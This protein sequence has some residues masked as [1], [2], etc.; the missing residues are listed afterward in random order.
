M[1]SPGVFIQEID[2]STIA[3][4]VSST[5]AVF[6][7][8]FTKGPVESYLLITSVEALISNFG[9]PTDTNYNDWYQAYNFLQYGNKLYIAR[10]VGTD[11]FNAGVFAPDSTGVV[12]T[13]YSVNPMI[14]KNFSEFENTIDSISMAGVNDKLFI[15]SRTPGSW[16]NS[17]SVAIA[18]STDFGISADAF[19]GIGLDSFFEYTPSAGEYGI[20]VSDGDAVVEVFTVSFDK[21]A[22]DF[23][24]KSIYIEDVINNKSNFIYV[25]D[26]TAN[27]ETL[28]SALGANVLVLTSG[29]DVAP[30]SGDLITGYDVWSNKEEID[31][32]IVIGNELDSGLSAINLANTREDCIAFVGANYD[33]VGVKASAAVASILSWRK[34]GA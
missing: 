9:L 29:I 12:T 1:L 34:T 3:P 25:K 20:L 11:S 18:A 26:D 24:N 10:A 27:I 23:N 19:T 30:A 4:S 13:D 21:N 15:A 28:D 5:A 31:I 33:I 17:I 6:V 7:G 16:G 2:A 14:I 8:N 22:K 32:D